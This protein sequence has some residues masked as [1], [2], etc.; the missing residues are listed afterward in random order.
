MSIFGGKTVLV[1][2]VVGEKIGEIYAQSRIQR[3]I[4]TQLKNRV[5][6]NIIHYPGLKY[7]LFPLIP[8]HLL[9]P[10]IV[11]KK[12]KT[13]IVH[14][15]SQDQAH[16]LNYINSRK[17]IVTVLDIYPVYVLENVR[18]E[19]GVLNY[20]LHS[21]GVPQWV[22]GL[23]KARRII[24]ISNFTKRE[25]VEKFGHSP[26][27]IDVIY[28]GVDRSKYRPLRSFEKPDC[29][30]GGKT[31]LYA[32]TEDFRKNV[33]TLV[34]AFH[35]LKKKLPNVKM[36]KI[37]RPRSK[38]GRKKLLSLISELNL[39]DDVVFIEY[40]PE[41]DL[42]LYYNSADL[43]V[44]P[45]LYE[46]FGLP[47]LEAMACGTPIVSSNASSL[48]EVVGEAGIMVDPLNVDAFTNAMYK[49]LTNDGLRGDLIKKGLERAELFSWEKTADG[50][51]NVYREVSGER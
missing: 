48:P 4:C 11:K 8:K 27:K 33:G 6:F 1:N 38:A 40:V 14:I 7:S 34:K 25:L 3:M 10:I 35:K 31:I 16:V 41:E 21:I 50:V 28:L 32:G 23:K 24:A 51:F 17:S 47:P 30:R 12:M 36:V 2:Y 45:S 46:G 5:D 18:K 13:G 49:I 19:Y 20:M 39:K 22:K 44:F 43:F 26:E 9:Y 42:P 37:G 15:A 29:F